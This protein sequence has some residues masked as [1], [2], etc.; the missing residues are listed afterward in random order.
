MLRSEV[1][2]PNEAGAMRRSNSVW[3]ANCAVVMQTDGTAR[4]CQDWRG[5]NALLEPIS[6]RLGG[7][8]SIGEERRDSNCFTPIDQPSECIHLEITE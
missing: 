2:T 1:D 8:D 6:E 4:V 3:A 5:L 7:I